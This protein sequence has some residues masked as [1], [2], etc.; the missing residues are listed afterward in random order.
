MLTTSGGPLVVTA[1]HATTAYDYEYYRSRLADPAILVDAVAICVF[2]APLLAVPAGGTRR[3][4]YM[5]F[6][7]V[8]L[9]MAARDLLDGRPGF[10]DLRVRWSP[11]RDTCHVVEW[12]AQPPADDV[13]R[14]RFYGYSPKSIA[15]FLAA[16]T[17]TT[18][19]PAL[20]SRSPTVP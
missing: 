4:G 18:S 19:S 12:G 14:G 16:K 6:D 2:R 11:Y 8:T 15:D 10:P 5:S 3:G 1:L 20:L 7:L 17:S 13:S 9:A